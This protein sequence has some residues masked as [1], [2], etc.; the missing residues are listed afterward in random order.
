VNLYEKARAMGLDERQIKL[1]Q[2][3]KECPV[4]QEQAQ[5]EA[6]ARVAIHAMAYD[7]PGQAVHIPRYGIG[8]VPHENGATVWMRRYPMGVFLL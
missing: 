8:Y 4:P 2:C 7:N 3:V 6:H 1:A 5:L